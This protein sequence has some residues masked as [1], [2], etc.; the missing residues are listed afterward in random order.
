MK[1][2]VLTLGMLSWLLGFG[3]QD[4]RSDMFV[5][6][7]A[8]APAGKRTKIAFIPFRYPNCQ[9]YGE[10][11][12]GVYGEPEH[13]DIFLDE[14]EE[15]LPT[16]PTRPHGECDDKPVRGLRVEYAPSPGYIGDDK[17]VYYIDNQRGETWNYYQTIEV[18]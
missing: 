12:F 3:E 14:A 11:Q 10:V 7:H 9:S 6:Q 4:R 8:V 1:A 13:G 2:F 17:A 5:S 16:N 18:K 15:V